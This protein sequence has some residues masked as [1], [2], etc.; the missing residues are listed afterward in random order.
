[1]LLVLAAHVKILHIEI[2]FLKAFCEYNLINF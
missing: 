1:M 2:I